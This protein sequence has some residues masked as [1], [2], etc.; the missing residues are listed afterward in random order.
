MMRL[1]YYFLLLCN[2]QL[3]PPLGY[4]GP[5]VDRRSEKK[6]AGE[7]GLIAHDSIITHSFY[8]DRFRVT[9]TDDMGDALTHIKNNNNNNNSLPNTSQHFISLFALHIKVV[10]I[11]NEQKNTFFHSNRNLN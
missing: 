10:V 11:K 3:K 8:T 2:Q 5:R 4:C 1:Y 9:R 6:R 7:M